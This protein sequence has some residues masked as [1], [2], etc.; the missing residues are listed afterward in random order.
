[1]TLAA[2]SGA[3]ILGFNVGM[4]S[5]VKQLANRQQVKI[6]LYKVIY[7]LLDDIRDIL[8]ELLPPEIVETVTGRL[9]VLGVF[10]ITKTAVICGGEV[11]EGKVE[12]KRQL[13]IMRGEE[14]L[15]EGTIL[16]L[17]KEKQAA[18]EV[19][20]GEQC[21]MDVV[22]TTAIAVGDELVLY[23][24]ESRARRV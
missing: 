13:H 11:I 24:T 6:Q 15:G 7:E 3:L 23:T 12:P 19:I 14:Q 22:T 9:K 4:N 16:S 20:E 21:G 17:Q 5:T 1:V 10:K 8:S 18:R 2:S